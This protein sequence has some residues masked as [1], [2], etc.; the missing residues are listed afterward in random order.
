MAGF[1][2]SG[3]TAMALFLGHSVA[4]G[5]TLALMI[6]LSV[7]TGWCS[8]K[9]R[10]NHIQRYGPLY[11]TLIA[12]PLIMM[13]PTTHFLDDIFHL[14]PNWSTGFQHAILACTYTGFAFL[15]IGSLWN[16][17][18]VQKL[19]D[20]RMLWRELKMQDKDEQEE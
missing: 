11:C 13:D 14:F 3:A 19:R 18:I 2:G 8:S 4:F 1:V 20:I 16:A 5:V 15:V 9:R 7:Y 17:N 12:A 6:G 10:G